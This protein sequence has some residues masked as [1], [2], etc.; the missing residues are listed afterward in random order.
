MKRKQ[1]DG[2]KSEAAD[3]QVLV[4]GALAFDAS[5]VVRHSDPVDESIVLAR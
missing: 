1:A 2:R 3:P 4:M 5:V